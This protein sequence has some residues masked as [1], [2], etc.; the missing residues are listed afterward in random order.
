VNVR[1]IASAQRN[2]QEA[3]ADEVVRSELYHQVA[4]VTA[5]IPPLRE[6]PEDIP[7]IAST[8]AARAP[9]PRKLTEQ[10]L[11]QLAS[12]AWPGNVRELRA[13]VLRTLALGAAGLAQPSG[14]PVHDRTVAISDPT[15]K[16]AR[17]RIVMAFEAQFITTL[18]QKHNGN[19][20]AAAREAKISRKHLHELLRRHRIG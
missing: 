5:K 17:E 6:R 19:V 2:L 14:A 7:H 10:E 18:M 15:Y 8:I 4:V 12:R 9:S 20:S 1:V 3:V 11:H 13:V 16:E